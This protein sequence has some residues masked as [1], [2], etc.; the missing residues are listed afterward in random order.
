ME[1][2]LFEQIGGTYTQVGDYLLPDIEMPKDKPIG[3]LG[4]R[5]YHHLR[6]TNC[7]LFRQQTVSRG[8]ENTVANELFSLTCSPSAINKL[9]KGTR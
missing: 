2:S 7:I 5:H 3:V 1:N 4:T 9:S 8:L 6:K